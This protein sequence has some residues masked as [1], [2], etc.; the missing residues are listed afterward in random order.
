MNMQTSTDRN[1]NFDFVRRQVEQPPAWASEV[2]QSWEE[3]YPQEKHAF[4]QSHYWTE[5]GSINVFRVVGTDHWDYQGKSWLD[6]LTGGKRMQRNLQALLDN[7]S[8]YLQPTERR[9]AIHYNTLDGLSFYVGSDG[10]HRTCIARFFLAE[11]QKSQL[12]DVT[13]NHYQSTT[14]STACTGNSGNRS[15]CKGYLCKSIRSA[16]SWV[17]KILLAGRWTPTRPH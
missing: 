11:Q 12:H 9:P 10:N 7:P 2:L 1:L 4:L 13:L 8:Y 15:C 17:G 16:C 5:T 14:V 3:A 6:F